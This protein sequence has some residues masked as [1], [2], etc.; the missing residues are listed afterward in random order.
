MEARSQGVCAVCGKGGPFEAHHVLER[1]ELSRRGL[2]EFDTRGALR[3][4]KEAV[5]NCHSRHTTAT[6]R[7]KF[8][9]LTEENI[10]YAFEALGPFAIDYLTRRYE[11][12][13]GRVEAALQRAEEVALP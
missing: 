10:S 2:P 8:S 12:D 4:C 3:L 11:V 13:D 7:V 5:G 6:R 9:E 1:Q